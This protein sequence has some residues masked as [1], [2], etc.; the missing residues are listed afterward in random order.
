MTSNELVFPD[1]NRV[2]QSFA[3]TGI[4]EIYKE[5]TRCSMLPVTEPRSR[6]ARA[7]PYVMPQMDP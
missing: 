5:T 6:P 2:D 7:L 1:L 4:K 3:D